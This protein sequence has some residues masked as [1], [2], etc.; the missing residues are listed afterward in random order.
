MDLPQ[1]KMERKITP[2]MLIE[3]DTELHCND[4]LT[5]WQLQ[6]LLKEKHPALSL[7]TQCARKLIGWIC[8][9]PH[10]CQRCEI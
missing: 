1:K 3:M 9:S 10:Y 8:T 6:T 2:E 7:D 4:E 5:A